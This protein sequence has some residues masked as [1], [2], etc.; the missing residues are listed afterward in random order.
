[1]RHRGIAWRGSRTA[2]AVRSG[3][4]W[5]PLLT[6]TRRKCAYLLRDWRRAVTAELA[7][8]GSTLLDLRYPRALRYN[9]ASWRCVWQ[10]HVANGRIAVGRCTRA[11]RRAI[12]G[13]P[14]KR[15]AKPGKPGARRRSMPECRIPLAQATR[16]CAEAPKD[17]TAIDDIDR[18]MERVREHGNPDVPIGLTN[19]KGH[20][21]SA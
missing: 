18:H 5:V 8:W 12:S 14:D 16:H 6:R 3:R 10:Q 21:H 9:L 7:A 11:A 17:R 15:H 2:H 4:H 1:M 13:R 20:G 19:R